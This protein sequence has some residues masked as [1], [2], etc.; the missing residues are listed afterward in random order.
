MTH[1]YHDQLIRLTRDLAV[2][3]RESLVQTR[4]VAP[5]QPQHVK[6]FV[7][8]NLDKRLDKLSRQVEFVAEQF[9]D[10]EPLIV[11]FIKAHP[12]AA[13]SNGAQDGDRLLEWLLQEHEVSDEQLDYI[14]CQRARHA[15]EQLAHQRRLDYV[16]FHE[17]SSLLDELLCQL[18]SDPLLRIYLNP[19]HTWARFVTPVLLEDAQ[20]PANVLFFASRGQ[21][22]TALLELE[23][24]TL[25]NELADFEPC[26]LAEWSS[27]TQ[28]ADRHQLEELCRDLAEMGLVCVG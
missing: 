2:P 14:V 24:Q 5:S 26:T 8:G 23:G 1:S 6:L 28:L 27:L 15:I 22:A 16:R 12:L 4:L 25:I 3:N 11:E 18:A 10:F 17:R 20:P 21:V 13:L 19:I 9:E 7:D